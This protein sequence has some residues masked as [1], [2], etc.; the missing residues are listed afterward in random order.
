MKLKTV[1]YK[2]G[3]CYSVAM[4]LLL[5]NYS[6]IQSLRLV[7]GYPILNKGKRKGKRFGHA[8]LELV[9]HCDEKVIDPSNQTVLVHKPI[10][11]ILGHIVEEDCHIYTVDEAVE[12]MTGTQHCG[13]WVES[14][15]GTVFARKGKHARN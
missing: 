4:E 7:H 10:Y 6:K 1:E 9:V 12:L 11:Y 8:W 2:P 3:L 15:P 13:P 14:K 5:R